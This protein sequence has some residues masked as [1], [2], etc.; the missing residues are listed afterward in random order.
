[1]GSV[2]GVTKKSKPCEPSG[3]IPNRTKE[4]KGL[5]DLPEFSCV[6]GVLAC[7]SIGHLCF[8]CDDRAKND[9]TDTKRERAM[10]FH[11]AFVSPAFV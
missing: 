2:L 5:N 4:T 3:H 9:V 11:P 7:S 10:A 1:M 6:V 8:S